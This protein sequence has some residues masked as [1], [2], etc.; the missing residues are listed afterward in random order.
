MG[1]CLFSY[2]STLPLCLVPFM[3]VVVCQLLL[4]QFVLL[5]LDVVVAGRD[6]LF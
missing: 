6:V 3:F 4:L 5:S 1:I 2:P